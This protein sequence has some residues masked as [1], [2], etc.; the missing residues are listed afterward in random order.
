MLVV[1][2]R[3]HTA[4]D[5]VPALGYKHVPVFCSCSGRIEL[6]VFTCSC[7]QERRNISK[8]LFPCLP[9]KTE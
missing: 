4:A 5:W 3:D 8:L 2:V 1:S 9:A 6:G 7:S